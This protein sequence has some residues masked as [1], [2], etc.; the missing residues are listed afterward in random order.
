MVQYWPQVY[1]NLSTRSYEEYPSS[2]SLSTI[3]LTSGQRHVPSSSP[4]L[5]L[6]DF[7]SLATDHKMKAPVGS[8]PVKHRRNCHWFYNYFLLEL[9]RGE[10]RGKREPYQRMIAE[11]PFQTLR[12]VL[13]TMVSLCIWWQL[14]STRSSNFSKFIDHELRM[15]LLSFATWKQTI[16]IGLSIFATSALDTTIS[17]RCFSASYIEWTQKF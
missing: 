2:L 5:I 17:E 9:S 14:F 6:T 8:Q 12:A 7:F 11:S 15:S 3:E 10:G 16:P 4:A 13:C 1:N